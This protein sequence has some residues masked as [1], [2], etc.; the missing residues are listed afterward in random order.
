MGADVGAVVAEAERRHR[1]IM[2][3]IIQKFEQ[4]CRTAVE[5]TALEAKKIM[6]SQ[7]HDADVEA[8]RLGDEVVSLRETLKTAE[9]F[10]NERDKRNEDLEAQ[11]KE[12]GRK[13]RELVDEAVATKTSRMTAREHELRQSFLAQLESARDLN[14]MLQEENDRLRA[15]YR[16]PCTMFGLRI[17]CLQPRCPTWQPT[18]APAKLLRSTRAG[19]SMRSLCQQRVRRARNLPSQAKRRPSPGRQE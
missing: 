5:R 6:D 4:H 9:A 14:S 19:R 18:P 17:T 8:K 10:I 1:D 15:A 12:L 13:S 2:T 16:L 3:Q 11:L 7:A